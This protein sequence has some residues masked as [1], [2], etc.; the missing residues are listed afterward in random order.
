M[1]RFLIASSCMVV[2]LQR[3]LVALFQNFAIWVQRLEQVVL[4]RGS[5]FSSHVLY[6]VQF[7]DHYRGMIVDWTNSKR[8]TQ[9]RSI[10]IST[11]FHFKNLQ[12]PLQPLWCRLCVRDLNIMQ[13]IDK[14]LS[15]FYSLRFI[16]LHRA[17]SNRWK[18]TQLISACH[19][20]HEDKR[21]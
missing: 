1:F 10:E 20:T 9:G 6:I 15:M 21:L 2:Y 16:A 14:K 7:T 19:Q 11:K 17:Y 3:V 12:L 4:Q 5:M 18:E 8:S 13:A